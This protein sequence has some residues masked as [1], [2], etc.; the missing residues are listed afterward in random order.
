M[1]K[2]ER[3]FEGEDLYGEEFKAYIVSPKVAV[4][5]KEVSIESSRLGK[6][7]MP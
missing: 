6:S 4:A 2:P 7:K 1:G 3:I 5:V